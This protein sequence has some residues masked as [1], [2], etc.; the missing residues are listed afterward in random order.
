MK[1]DHR[2]CDKAQKPGYVQAAESPLRWF[3]HRPE[4]GPVV[5]LDLSA[6]NPPVTG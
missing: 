5:E 3:V 6:T 4:H 2:M 1:H